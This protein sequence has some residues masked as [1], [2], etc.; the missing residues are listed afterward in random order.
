MISQSRLD[1]GIEVNV[2][3]HKVRVDRFLAAGGFAEI[4][5]VIFIELLNEFDESSSANNLKPGSKACLK[6]V[7][8]RGTEGLGELRAEVEVMR[9][10]KGRAGVVQYYDS[11]AVRKKSHPNALSTE[12]L[13]LEFNSS[14]FEVLLLMELCPN[15]S[16]LDYMNERLNTR[17]QESEIW[18]ILYDISIGVAQMH[19]LKD[20]LIH[21]DLKIENILV[22]AESNF[23]LCD[24]GSAKSIS[25]LAVTPEEI[26]RQAKEILSHTTPQYRSPEMID[27]YRRLPINEKSDIWALGVLLY[28]MLFYVTPFESQ[29]QFA[30]LHSEYVFPPSNYSQGLIQLITAMLMESP[31]LRPNIYQVVSYLCQMKQKTVPIQ[32]IYGQGNFDWKAFS[33]YRQKLNQLQ[34]G[35][36]QLNQ[37]FSQDKKGTVDINEAID[38]DLKKRLLTDIPFTSG[39]QRYHQFTGEINRILS[40]GNE[41]EGHKDQRNFYTV[42]KLTVEHHQ[43]HNNNINMIPFHGDSSREIYEQS[44]QELSKS[45]ANMERNMPNYAFQPVTNSNSIP[46]HRS[47]QHIAPTPHFF[48]GI[49][50]AFDSHTSTII[51]NAQNGGLNQGPISNLKRMSNANARPSDYEL[52]VNKPQASTPIPQIGRLSDTGCKRPQISDDRSIGYPERQ[53]NDQLTEKNIVRDYSRGHNTKESGINDAAAG[54]LT[55]GR[56]MSLSAITNDDSSK[57]HPKSTNGRHFSAETQRRPNYPEN[58]F[59]DNTE[60]LG[61]VSVEEYSITNIVGERDSRASSSKHNTTQKEPKTTTQPRKS[62]NLDYQEINFNKDVDHGKARYTRPG[63]AFRHSH[64]HHNGLPYNGDKRSQDLERVTNRAKSKSYVEEEL[65]DRTKSA[66][67]NYGGVRQSLDLEAARREAIRDSIPHNSSSKKANFFS[68]FKSEKR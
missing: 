28:K 50:P 24:F 4:Y 11:N 15:G 66:R 10:L 67:Q 36:V 1:I 25:A 58:L 5:E 59:D 18:R 62:L 32:D 29:G 22:D 46:Q 51:T 20:P 52:A 34:N 26:S 13:D 3:S 17:L 9:R 47:M 44:K 60:D 19:Y 38:L 33:D 6:R 65:T 40:T 63:S 30:I 21:R 7:L 48:Q 16:L 39:Q 43:E 31:Y 41:V 49:T 23:K 57:L 14:E 61:D 37:S 45:T 12:T 64:S 8:V 56:S 68:L 42:P 54:S 27:L 2:G 35:I 55:V 53:R